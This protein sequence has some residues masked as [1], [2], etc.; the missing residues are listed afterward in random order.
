MKNRKLNNIVNE[1]KYHQGANK[2]ALEL[3]RDMEKNAKKAFEKRKVS[4]KG[5]TGRINKLELASAVMNLPEARNAIFAISVTWDS[6][7]DGDKT[8]WYPVPSYD[9]PIQFV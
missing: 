8:A 1:V 4:Y 6:P 5:I 2:V 7:V 9:N 3:H